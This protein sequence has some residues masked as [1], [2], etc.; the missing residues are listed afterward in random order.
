MDDPL[1][2]LRQMANHT[3]SI[4]LWTHYVP[5]ELFGDEGVWTRTIVRVEDRTFEGRSVPH[6]IKS[7]QQMGEK[8]VYCGGVY[9]TASWIR[10]KDILSELRRLGFEHVSTTLDVRD[11]P[12]GPCISIA[13]SK[14]P[15]ALQ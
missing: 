12:N 1:R 9:T 14:S 11:H 15:L 6:Y 13:A 5:D 7:Y 8:A 4:Y 10:K 3:N 2:L